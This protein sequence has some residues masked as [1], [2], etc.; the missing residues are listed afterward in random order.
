MMNPI[1][2]AAIADVHCPRY[3]NEFNLALS[4]CNKPDLFLFAGDMINRGKIDEYTNVLDAVEVQFGQDVPLI[5]CFGNEDPPIHR[6]ELAALT[7]GRVTLLDDDSVT[8]TIAKSSV[9]IIGMSVVVSNLSSESSVEIR[10]VF[11]ERA[12]QLKRLLRSA[13]GSGNI[14]ILLMH[15]SPLQETRPSEYTWWVAEAVSQYPPN[16]I[17]HGH[18]HDAP[19]EKVEIGATTIWN[20]ALPINKSITEIDYWDTKMT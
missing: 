8:I 19:R 1:R 6:D 2:I 5:A 4:K 11:E 15:F 14:V 17:I 3:L 13:K 20:V 9:T 16:A 7:E 18:L 12:K 10:G